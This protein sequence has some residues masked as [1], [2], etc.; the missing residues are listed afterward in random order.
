MTKALLKFERSNLKP[1][2]ASLIVLFSSL[3]TVIETFINLRAYGSIATL[4]SNFDG[5]RFFSILYVY[6]VFISSLITFILLFVKKCP[7]ILLYLNAIF[8]AVIPT[9][10]CLN[11]AI[12]NDSLPEDGLL[13]EETYF[14]TYSF[15]LILFDVVLVFAS[16]FGSILATNLLKE[17][18]SYP[19]ES[20][21]RVL[22]TLPVIIMSLPALVSFTFF[23]PPFDPGY[24]VSTE[25]VAFPITLVIIYAYF[26][27]YH[28]FNKSKRLSK[29]LK[30]ILPLI[31]MVV[32][33]GLIAVLCIIV[34][35]IGIAITNNTTDSTTATSIGEAVGEVVGGTI[36]NLALMLV[37]VVIILIATFHLTF[38]LAF[39]GAIF[40]YDA[41]GYK[42]K[43]NSEI[44]DH[45][46]IET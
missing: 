45:P 8:L 15:L 25:H 12:Y 19:K 40:A 21:Y 38:P 9:F 28:L 2:F 11:E 42:K 14:K 31:T 1:F 35:F 3:L 18:N 46:T 16:S 5:F 17:N 30:I 22:A 23:I 4:F 39:L 33:V 10:W 6:L 29:I 13:Y 36:T 34:L 20:T 24:T 41:F 43:D 37:G 27:L 7:L 32:F 44:K 26:F